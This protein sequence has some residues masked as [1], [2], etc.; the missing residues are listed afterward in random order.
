MPEVSDPSPQRLHPALAVVVGL[1]TS[2]LGC[3]LAFPVGDYLTKLMHVPDF[4]GQRGYALIFICAPLGL[5]V[6]FIIGLI[7]ALRTR[8]PGL[9]GFGAAQGLSILITGVVAGLLFVV[10]YLLSDKPPRIDGKRLTLD[11]ELR[12]PA[13]IKIPEQPDGYS[14]RV[15][16][17]NNGGQDRYAFIDWSSIS[18]RADATT[19]PGHVDLLTHSQN[20][21]LF[22][23]IGNEPGNSQFIEL[24]MPA[25]PREED[26]AWS[27]WIVAAQRADLS[28]VPEPEHFSL[29]YR[30][31][32][33]H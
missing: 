20:R 5:A 9:A 10:P 27:D 29:R 7:V 21:S 1:I 22:A 18:K 23:S 3:I 15:A 12:I 31:R 4:E 33:I 24:K 14:V 17:Y 26:K 13:T 6:G 32:P 11:F 19:I 2:I 30:V 8:R 16:L 25:S 28:P